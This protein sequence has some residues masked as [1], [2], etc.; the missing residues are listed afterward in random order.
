MS[1]NRTKVSNYK[2]DRNKNVLRFWCTECKYQTSV[3]C[4]E[5]QYLDYIGGLKCIQDIFPDLPNHDREI[6]ISGWCGI[7]YDKA[8]GWF[9]TATPWIDEYFSGKAT[10][11]LNTYGLLDVFVKPKSLKE[12]VELMYALHDYDG[13]ANETVDDS[14]VDKLRDIIYEATLDMEN[15]TCD[16]DDY[17]DYD[18]DEDE[19][20]RR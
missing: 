18:G 4:T 13:I 16:E 9:G 17:Y 1:V 15:E 3:A 20:E 19:D 6:L 10:D 5:E 11:L 7:C 2:F 12:V 8:I 14:I